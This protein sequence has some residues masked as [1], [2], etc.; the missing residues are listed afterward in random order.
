MVNSPR[1]GRLPLWPALYVFGVFAVLGTGVAL[2]QQRIFSLLTL[3]ALGLL[4]AT[5]FATHA[6]LPRR[7]R[8]WGRRVS[9]LLVGAG[10]FV[11][12]GIFGR[13]SFQIEGLWFYVLHGMMGGVVVHYLVAKLI[14][15]LLMGRAWCGWGCWTWMVLDYLPFPRGAKTRARRLGFLRVIHI[16]LSLALVLSLW[17]FGYRHGT[18]WTTT[19]GLLWFLGGNAFYYAA[20]IGLAFAMKDNRA[21]CKVLCPV[22]VILRQSARFSLLK[23]DTDARACRQCGNCA[24]ACPMEVDVPSYVRSG[25]RVLDSECTLCQ[26][27]ISGCPEN[28]LSLGVRPTREPS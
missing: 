18:E 10:L 9:L 15:P 8:K 7:K 23:V 3:S 26:T 25:Q 1:T 19:D 12:V 13:Q 11:G 14:G 5:G 27:C 6:L 2:V 24:R 4:V 22:S 20:A 21:F 17:L 28:A 16:G